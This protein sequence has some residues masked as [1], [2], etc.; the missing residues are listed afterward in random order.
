MQAFWLGFGRLSSFA[1]AFVSAAILS[2]FLSKED[3]GTYKQIMYLYASFSLIFMAGLPETLTYFLPKLKKEEQ[4]YLVLQ[5]EIIFIFLGLLFS[6][7]LYFGSS[8]IA[9]ILNNPTLADALKIYAPVPLLLMPTF[10]MESIYMNE[11]KS[12]YQAIYLIFSRFMVLCGITLPVIFYQ[13]SCQVAL[14]GLVFSSACMLIVA[15][16][17]IAKPYKG[18]HCQRSHL[19]IRDVIG[20]SIPLLSADFALMLFNSADQFFISRYFGE[21]VFAEYSNGFIQFPLATMVSGS[22][23]TVLI[24]M[25]SQANTTKKLNEAIRSWQNAIRKTCLLLYPIL[26]FCFFFATE[27]VT[28]I[29]GKNY[30]CSAIYL[31]LIHI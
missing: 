26:V 12:H 24:P 30:T 20:Y 4:K 2:R 28:F 19:N 7:C 31:S 5:F 6:S 1:L 15:L 9:E 16:F 13:A 21:A 11:H 22:V 18:Y 8:T 23:L 27:I 10:T 17:L 3:Y 25:F 29:Y 14:H